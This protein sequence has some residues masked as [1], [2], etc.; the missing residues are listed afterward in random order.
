M[1]QNAFDSAVESYQAALDAFL[2]GDPKPVQEHF[3]QSDD[4]TLANPLGPPRRGRAAV[5]KAIAH[6][7]ANFEDGHMEFEE[8]SRFQ[9]DDLGYAVW[10][11]RG[12][13]R[14]VG[15]E[16]MAPSSLRV[17]MIFRR[18][19]D[20]WMVVHRH[21]DPITTNRPVTTVLDA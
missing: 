15:R 6:A 16:V 3:S 4:V 18:E 10:L 13:V 5:D 21:A 14:L 7:A 9:T 11:E 8:I 20:A 17:T 12:Q 2:K 19:G 1:S